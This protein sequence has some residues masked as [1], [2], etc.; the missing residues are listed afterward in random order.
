MRLRPMRS[1]RCPA[2]GIVTNETS[3]ATISD[4]QQEVAR[5]VQHLRPV[6]EDEGEINIGGRLLGHAREAP[7]G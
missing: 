5:T 1:D 6:S 3:P 4:G 2:S 7:P